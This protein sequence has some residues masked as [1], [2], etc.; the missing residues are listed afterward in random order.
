VS[1]KHGD[2]ALSNNVSSDERKRPRQP[3]RNDTSDDHVPVP[4]AIRSTLVGVTDLDRSVAFY[5]DIGPF[6]EVARKDAVA[7]L[8][9]LSPGSLL[10]V[11][12]ERQG[13]HP[14]RHGQDSLGLRSISFNVGSLGE[15][16]RIESRLR[17][18]ERFTLRWK[19]GD[20]GPIELVSGRD[21]DNQPVVFVSYDESAVLGTNY[22]IAIADLVHSL[23]V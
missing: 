2:P 18:D 22:Y 21:P 8:R 1:P 20:D 11:L 15:L 16:D 13:R 23:D 7:V 12:R 17:D 3:M 10:L 19:M 6:E 14:V 9:H 5:T 4:W